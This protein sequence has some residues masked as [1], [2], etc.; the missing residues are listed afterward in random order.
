LPA[1][2]DSA[3]GSK[4]RQLCPFS[5]R[6]R[7]YIQNLVDRSNSRPVFFAGIS[8][9]RAGRSARLFEEL[10]A[11][12]QENPFGLDRRVSRDRPTVCRRRDGADATRRSGRGAEERSCGGSEG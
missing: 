11:H 4:Q 7:F 12:G 1:S 9:R 10:Q 6:V 5:L 8:K 2:N 3:L